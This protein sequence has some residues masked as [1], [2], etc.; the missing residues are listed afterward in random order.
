MRLLQIASPALMAFAVL[1]GSGTAA[2]ADTFHNTYLAPGVQASS[3]STHTET[4]SSF[5]GSTTNFNGSGITGTYTGAFSISGANLYGGADGTGSFITTSSSYTLT[6]SS[7]VNYFGMWFSALDGGN[8]LSFY[9]DSTLVF[10]FS[11]NDYASLVGVCPTGAA[12]P[13]YCGNPNAAFYNQDSDQQY[14]FLNFYDT[15]GSFNKIV[16]TENPQIGGFESDNHTLGTLTGDP[17][18]TP[19]DPVPEPSTFVLGFSGIVAG[20]AGTRRQLMFRL[21]HRA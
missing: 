9:S 3:D 8:Q 1:C 4:F 15:N 18:G 20:I 14:A 10:S 11:P 16:F 12:E 17:S 21:R 19:L 2:M 6:L 5:N 7:A 13:N